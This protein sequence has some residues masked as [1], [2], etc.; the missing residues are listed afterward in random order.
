MAA[1]VD[2]AHRAGIVHRDFKSENVFLVP[3]T[4]EPGGLRAVVADF[5]IAR[6]GQDEAA[7]LTQ[8]GGVIGTPAYMAPEQLEGQEV[9]AAADIY[10][11]G[12][13]VYEMV[14]GHLPFVG[15]TAISTAVR[16]LTEAPA[17]PRSFVPDLDQRWEAMILRCLARLPEERFANAAQ[18]IDSLAGPPVAP[19]APPPAAP[20]P[21][22]PAAR[23]AVD[24]APM[25]IVAPPGGAKARRQKYLAGILVALLALAAGSAVMRIRAQ[26]A[27]LE[28]VAPRRAVAVLGFRNVAGREDAAWLSTALAEM[29]ATE[30]S[31]GEGLRAVPGENVAR[32]KIELGLTDSET[33]TRET[34]DGVRAVLGADYVVLGSYTALG[35]QSGGRLRL[36]LRLQDA[37]AG[38]TVASLGEAGTEAE[39]FELVQ[40]VGRALRDRL[41]LKPPRGRSFWDRFSPEATR[42]YAE[43][44]V[45]LR[46]FEPLQARDLL[47]RAVTADPESPLAHAALAEA[48]SALGYGEKALV[49]SR[50]AFELSAELG[51]EDRLAVEGRYREASRD[52]GRAAEIYG[53]LRRLYPDSLEYGLRLAAVQTSAAQ[54]KEALRTIASLR[55]LPPPSNDDPRIHLAASTAAASLSDYKLQQETAARAA[56]GGTRTGARLLVAQARVAEGWAS[57]NLGDPA[58][59]ER[60][61]LEAQ[62]LFAEAGDRAGEAHALSALA[63]ALY[64]RGDLSGASSRFTEALAI[65]R[66][67]G[68]LSGVARV[69]NNTAVVLKNQGDPARARELYEETLSISRE[70][71]DRLGE[72]S[73]LN[74]IAAVLSQEGDLAG[75][76]RKLEESLVIRR[77]LADPSGVAYAVS[78]I[79]VVLHRQGELA[80]A[81]RQH[82]EALRLR[83]ETGQ[84]IGEMASLYQLGRVLLDQNEP[85]AARQQFDAALS[86]CREIG[87]KSCTASSLAGLAETLAQG[88]DTAGGRRAAEEALALR[89]EIGERTAAAETRAQLGWLRREEGDPAAAAQELLAARDA[90]RSLRSPDAEALAGAWL[91]RAQVESNDLPRA[92]AAA[93]AAGSLAQRSQ[94]PATRLAVIL[95]EARVAAAGGDRRQA[96]ER[97]RSVETEARGLGLL[98]LAYEARLVAAESGALS[99]GHEA[100]R[101]L[102]EEAQ[103]HGLGAIARRALVLVRR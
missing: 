59:A 33:L 15:D 51:R 68:D 4:A 74:N 81:R 8:T 38:V 17:S 87:N 58:R 16:R 30:L 14:T 19:S 73:A 69:L 20:L 54:G 13:V 45:K 64:D 34:L 82:E 27:E 80:E 62:R 37:T 89:E 6:A 18:A 10:A 43:G 94:S 21:A 44:V 88:G 28:P 71:G 57:R 36:D 91:A 98:A 7:R 65:Y 70:T 50:Q 55:V 84:R 101:A 53:E 29:L 67:V 75:A 60:A 35:P 48:W 78:N 102:A 5:G 31:T 95:A 1:A 103:A 83:R 23:P 40:R 3:D 26:R 32:A 61:C 72:A 96:G 85:A 9:T 100:V 92:R 76:K 52:W 66:Q 79:G 2:A 49:A 97:L 47:E 99:G 56:E 25:P 24:T 11:F 46:S 86:G 42:L 63:G 41:G 39:L 90:L 93:E 22:A 77:E 12:L